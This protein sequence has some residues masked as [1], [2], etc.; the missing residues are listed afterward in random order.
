MADR[1]QYTPAEAFFNKP[2]IIDE[3]II[4]TKA[5]IERLDYLMLPSGID[6]SKPQV[7]TTPEDIMAK[8]MA[9]KADLEAYLAGLQRE[10]FTA[11]E[12][13]KTILQ[14]LD[15]KDPR[16]ATILTEYYI[17]HKSMNRIARD[18]HYNRQHVYRLRTEALKEAWHL[19]IKRR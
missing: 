9:E 13:I 12:N 14:E 8:Y 17:S 11:K 5:E 1:R 6:I 7:Q 4:K 3:K 10:Y 18:H 15:Q 16:A 19:F 2:Y